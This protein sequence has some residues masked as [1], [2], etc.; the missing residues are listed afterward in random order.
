MAL[1]IHGRTK[2]ALCREIIAPDDE[3]IGTPH[4]IG[5]RNDSLWSYSDAAFHRRCFLAWERREEFV[6]RFNEAAKP[7]VFGNGKR[8]HMQ[9]DGDIIQI[10]P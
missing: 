1:I 10:E 7:F 9:D 6:R 4:F 2:C 8:N 5:D 3:L